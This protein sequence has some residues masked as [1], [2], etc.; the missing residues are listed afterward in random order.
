MEQV[1]TV[2]VAGFDRS[3]VREQLLAMYGTRD[4]RLAAWDELDRE[5]SPT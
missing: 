1:L 4:P 5:V 3:W 2:Q